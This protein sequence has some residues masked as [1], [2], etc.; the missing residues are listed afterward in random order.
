[1]SLDQI[2]QKIITKVRRITGRI[3]ESQITTDQIKEY[4]TDFFANDFPRNIVTDALNSTFEFATKPNIDKYPLSDSDTKNLYYSFQPPVYFAGKRGKFFQN[5]EHFYSNFGNKLQ[6]TKIIQGNGTAG[7]YKAQVGNAPIL[8]NKVTISALDDSGITMHYVDSPET[9]E[10]GKFKT[11]QEKTAIRG[12]VN[13]LKG[14]IAMT[15]PN[16]VP[17][18]QKIYFSYIPYVPAEP[19]AILFADDA[20]FV[21]PVPD[22]SY[23]ISMNAL[24]NPESLENFPAPILTQWWQYL[25]LG[26]AKKIFEDSQDLEGVQSIM[27]SYKEQE[28][29]VLRRTLEQNRNQRTPTIYTNTIFD[30][31]DPFFFGER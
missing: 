12:T 13:Y 14:E 20:F 26:A 5:K 4:L 19:Q 17:T 29:L 24:K 2:T 10:T 6:I 25:A 18:N 1:M 23:L 11:F 30:G 9:R 28:S 7:E 21:R 22:R 27:P 16:A 15:F 31:I 3:S 8:Q